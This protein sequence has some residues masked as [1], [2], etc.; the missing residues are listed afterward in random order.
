MQVAVEVEQFG[1]GDIPDG[2][3]DQRLLLVPRFGKRDAVDDKCRLEDRRRLD[4]QPKAIA[5]LIGAH[6]IQHRQEFPP[7]AG[8]ALHPAFTRNTPQ[9]AAQLAARQGVVPRQLALGDAVGQLPAQ[10][11]VGD[12]QV[13]R[14]VVIRKFRE[15]HGEQRRASVQHRISAAPLT[16]G[17]IA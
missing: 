1:V 2:A 13:G 3:V 7:M 9:D 15:R 6:G 16:D 8:Q 4:D 11:V 14:L 12:F 17:H 10:P 5:V